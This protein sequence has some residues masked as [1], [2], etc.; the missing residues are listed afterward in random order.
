MSHTDDGKNALATL[1]LA[2]ALNRLMSLT[3]K[4]LLYQEEDADE[5]LAISAL[6][7]S[8]EQDA[9]SVDNGALRDVEV[10]A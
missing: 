9:R 6:I 8:A 4:F 3:D 5:V 7:A 2:E 10:T 1:K